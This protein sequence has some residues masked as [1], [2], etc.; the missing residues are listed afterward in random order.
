MARNE[1]RHAR[2]LAKAYEKVKALIAQD[3]ASEE[4]GRAAE[5]VQ[6]LTPAHQVELAWYVAEKHGGDEFEEFLFELPALP[7]AALSLER[8]LL[9]VN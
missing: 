1:V 7:A 8:I 2:A 6:R 5:A 3:N 4:G 9:C